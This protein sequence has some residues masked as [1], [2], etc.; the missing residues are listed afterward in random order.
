MLAV[1]AVIAAACGGD[2][3]TDAGDVAPA[4]AHVSTD[5]GSTDSQPSG[6]STDGGSEPTAGPF[7]REDLNFAIR[8]DP[9]PGSDGA[10]G[11][12]CAPGS[13]D[14]PDGVWFG[15]L[16][17]GT[18]SSV[19]FDLACFY[20]G[21]AATAKAGG[22]VDN[23]YLI[24]NQNPALRSVPVAVDTRVLTLDLPSPELS[25]KS[26]ADWYPVPSGAPPCP[27]TACLAWLYVNGGQATEIVEQ[28][29]P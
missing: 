17:S 25:I 4:P 27:G 19:E 10:G 18:D 8:P 5:D 7:V 16:R 21:D 3:E 15:F 9:L 29:L 11:S 2:D 1:F 20:F 23:D 28:F 26:Y 13:G 12:G 6:G 22:P 14:L 24:V